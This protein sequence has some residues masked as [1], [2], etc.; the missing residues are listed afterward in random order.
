MK[1][2]ILL[3]VNIL[4]TF[5]LYSQIQYTQTNSGYQNFIKNLSGPR[6]G[7]TIITN[8]NLKDELVSEFG[9]TSNIITQF[10]YQFEKQIMGDENVAGLVEGIIFLGGLEHGLFLPSLSGMF[11]ARFSSGYEFAIG[12][13]LSLGGAG[14]VLGFGK[15]IQA[16]NLNI[17]INFAWVPSTSRQN[18]ISNFDIE[19]VD[20]TEEIET[21]RTGNRFTLTIGFNFIS[22]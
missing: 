22:R 18:T 14:L 11:G 1:K 19:N 21:V 17:P 2:T 15:T 4:I 6:I 3:I 8:G 9:L 20:Y 13:N 5:N 16:G 12:P 7:F 10:G